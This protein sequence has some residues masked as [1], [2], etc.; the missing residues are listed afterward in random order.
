MVLH[1]FLQKNVLYKSF[2]SAKAFCLRMVTE[3]EIVYRV[4]AALIASALIGWE[5]E[6]K[7]K[8]AGLHTHVMVGVG[9]A[10]FTIASFLIAP[11][12]PAAIASGVV[13]GIGF[14]GAGMIFKDKLAV[15]GLT[16]AATIWATAAVGLSMGAG[17]F[18]LGGIAALIVLCTPL[19]PHKHQDLLFDGGMCHACGR[20]LSRK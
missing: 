4:A 11:T 10:V 6:Y 12:N 9:S 14:L 5:R 3:T 18:L 7:G 8:P 16:S 19:I 17:Y 13:T 15:F 20:K 1:L 2:Y